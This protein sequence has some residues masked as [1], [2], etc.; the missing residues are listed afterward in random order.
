MKIKQNLHTQPG[1]AGELILQLTVRLYF[2][3]IQKYRCQ[4]YYTEQILQGTSSAAIPG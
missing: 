3:V 4:D 1:N 2:S